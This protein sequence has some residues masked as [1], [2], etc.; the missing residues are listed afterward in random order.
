MHVTARQHQNP[1][2]KFTKFG[3]EMSTGQTPNHAK[4]C[5]HMTRSV[6]DIRNQKFLLP[7]IV[8]ESS[9]KFYG[10]R[11]CSPKPL[12]N[13][14]NDNTVTALKCHCI[15]MAT[16]EKRHKRTVWSWRISWLNMPRIWPTARL[17][18]SSDRLSILRCWR[19]RPRRTACYIQPSCMHQTD[20]STTII[21]R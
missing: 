14:I 6:R 1:E 19:P 2:S 15:K 20:L 4:F 12:T 7:E 11:C 18:S 3:E 21:Y 8:D 5:G 17:L 16:V 10:R 13:P 9:P